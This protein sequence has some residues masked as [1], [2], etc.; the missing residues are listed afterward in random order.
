MGELLDVHGFGCLGVGHAEEHVAGQ[1]VELLAVEVVV[2]LLAREEHEVA[3]RPL[4]EVDVGRLDVVQ[5]VRAW[6]V[7]AADE[8]D[9]VEAPARGLEYLLV[10]TARIGEVL[11][12]VE[13]SDDTQSLL[14][15]T[16]VEGKRPSPG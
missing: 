4:R 13:F 7:S 14:V 3:L 11:L 1:V 2:V 16:Q 5:E 10:H 12:A 6:L 15:H 8:G 9:D